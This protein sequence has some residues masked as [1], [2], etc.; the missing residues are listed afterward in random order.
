MGDF[1]LGELGGC[2]LITYE[3]II[4]YIGGNRIELILQYFRRWRYHFAK[5]QPN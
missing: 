2:H 5:W 1:K 3:I 4:N